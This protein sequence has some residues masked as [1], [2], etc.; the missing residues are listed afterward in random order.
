MTNQPE[1]TGAGYGNRTRLTGLGSHG[2]EQ[3]AQ[4]NDEGQPR[5]PAT[6]FE[7]RLCYILDLLLND[8]TDDDLASLCCPDC[9]TLI[10]T[11][12][13]RHYW[14]MPFWGGNPDFEL[15]KA[16][17]FYHKH[18]GVEILAIVGR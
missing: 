11:H 15:S 4:Q 16:R 3:N 12:G 14:P 2:S 9:L 13:V 6:A 17:A 10:D 8:T 5:R 1:N 7:I 18:L